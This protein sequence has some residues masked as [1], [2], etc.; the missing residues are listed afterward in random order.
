M[1]AQLNQLTTSMRKHYLLAAFI[2]FLGANLTFGQL[3][4]TFPYITSFEEETTEWTGT[5]DWQRANSFYFEKQPLVGGLAWSTNPFSFYSDADTSI[6]TSPRFDMS[7]LLNAYVSF[8]ISYSTESCCDEVLFQYSTDD[9]IWKD[10][11]TG[12]VNV[13][14]NG[15]SFAGRSSGY[16]T[17]STSLEGIGALDS[18]RFRFY[19]ETNASI[20]DVGVAVDNFIISD[21]PSSSTSDMV[22]LGLL[23]LDGSSCSRN[24]GFAFQNN[25]F[26]TIPI[27]RIRHFGK[28]GSI[29]TETVRNIPPFGTSMITLFGNYT[30]EDVTAWMVVNDLNR[31][32]DT[33]KA[34]ISVDAPIDLRSGI[35]RSNTNVNCTNDS[36]KIDFLITNDHHK[37]LFN[38]P[39][40]IEIADTTIITT[41]DSVQ[42]FCRFT[43]LL[44]RFRFANFL[45]NEGIY[46]SRIYT[47][48]STD[49]NR[50][51]D[52]SEFVLQY[53][54]ERSLPF[55]ENFSSGKSATVVNGQIEGGEFP[56]G[57]TITEDYSS[58]PPIIASEKLNF[59]GLPPYGYGGKGNYLNIPP[60]YFG[61]DSAY[62]PC[63]QIPNSSNDILMEFYYYNHFE[64]FAVNDYALFIKDI[65]T[66][67]LIRI[68]LSLSRT[69]NRED[70]YVKQIVNF[71]FVKGST[72][73]FT[74]MNYG[75]FGPAPS[76]TLSVD[77]IKI[78]ES[79]NTDLSVS[80]INGLSGTSCGL[81]GD[82]SVQITIQNL[83]QTNQIAFDVCYEV[84]GTNAVCESISGGVLGPNSQ[85]NYTF[86]KKLDIS[87]TNQYFIK[88]Y[89]KATG[90]AS[91]ANDTAFS[92]FDNTTTILPYKEDFDSIMVPNNGGIWIRDFNPS[93]QFYWNTNSGPTPSFNTG[94]T[95]D[96]N[97]STEGIYLHTET[98][99]GSSPGD[100][101]VLY[102]TN[103]FAFSGNE[104]LVFEYKF[105]MYGSTTGELYLVAIEGMDTIVLDSIKGQQQTAASDPWKTRRVP[106]KP[107]LGKAVQFAFIALAGN[108]EQGDIAIDN[109][110][111]Q[112]STTSLPEIKN[113]SSLKLY[114]N[115]TNGVLFLD[116]DDRQIVEQNAVVNIY[117]I[118]GQ[119]VH[120][121]HI[122]AQQMRF[123]VNHL[124][125]G[126]YILEVNTTEG[127]LRQRFILE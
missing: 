41:L 62:S 84:E 109:I 71:N 12:N 112:D 25:S 56:L 92:R 86:S 97:G 95:V 110:L 105:H 102:T 17:V 7:S 58:S 98:E 76:S 87:S 99:S 14:W 117:S 43:N 35:W 123:N 59:I 96:G 34:R 10:V 5:G 94:P 9:I 74:L 114:P 66:N 104:K 82:S 126:V 116:L 22:A 39:I 30:N 120:T 88:A 23:T 55:I 18:V 73:Q 27:L 15:N 85:T 78:Y 54:K 61:V 125:S 68:P 49:V 38:V 32:N 37:T 118:H 48:L 81:L 127:V 13:G 51:N 77:N 72:I 121:E 111:V 53:A 80:S 26:N 93:S 16:E 113:G 6:L 40:H 29:R 90:D 24:A 63:I 70:N 20:N 89:S 4:N 101:A 28:S 119:I 11:P 106:L 21:R 52:T 46:P 65:S 115:P 42:S 83:G 45:K 103:C 107:I 75:F 3:I 33:A 36:I 50:A 47:N 57:W 44:F 31:S 124:E 69:Q 67:R 19:F 64:S 100:S 8:A 79:G 2:T 60:S 1:F 122:N 91:V 108:G